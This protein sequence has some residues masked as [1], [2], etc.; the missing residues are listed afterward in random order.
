M[1]CSAQERKHNEELHLPAAGSPARQPGT[2]RPGG[3]TARARAA[4]LQAALAELGQGGYAALSIEQVAQRA[5]VNKTTIY[6]R[7]QTKDALLDDALASAVNAAVPV[8]DTGAVGTDLRQFARSIVDILTSD[9]GRAAASALFS[10]ATRAPQV[11]EIKRALLAGRHKL[12]APIAERAIQRGELPAG[13]DPRELIGLAV[14]PIYYRLLVTASQSTTRPPTAR[15]QPRSPPH[16]PAPA[17]SEAQ[18][19]EQVSARHHPPR[20]SLPAREC[21]D[22]TSLASDTPWHV[23]RQG[24]HKPHRLVTRVCGGAEH[25]R[26]PALDHGDATLAAIFSGRM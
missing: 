26:A 21:C 15:P 16:A 13:T 18:A 23:T 7:W 2:A 6:R 14:A 10:D 3:R 12:A 9:L 22:G 17:A 1:A 11:A 24:V 25:A 5:G 19:G 20:P 4:V 8:P